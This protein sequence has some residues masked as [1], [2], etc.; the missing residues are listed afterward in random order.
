MLG[1][2]IVETARIE[3]AAQNKRFVEKTF[4]AGVRDYFEKKN[5]AYE[6]LAGFWCVKEA[7]AKALGSGIRF[8]LTDVETSHDASGKPIAVLSGKAKE[9][10][11]NRCVE[12]SVSHTSTT[13]VAVAIIL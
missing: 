6:S 8:A 10:L 5:G 2:D 12:I 3:R 1:V 7:V 9:L 4:T 11:G 13:A